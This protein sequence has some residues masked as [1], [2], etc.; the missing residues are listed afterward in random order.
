[1]KNL[2]FTITIFLLLTGCGGGGGTDTTDDRQ[3]SESTR[4]TLPTPPEYNTTWCEP[5]TNTSWQWQLS[6]T[7]NSSYDVTV[8]D[9]DLFETTKETIQSLQDSGKKV[10]CYFSGGSFEDWRPDKANFPIE[11][12]GNNLDGWDGEKWLDIRNDKVKDI[13]KTRLDL[14][15]TKGCNGVEPD[16]IDGYDNSSGFDFTADDQLEYNT[17]IANEAH[18][19]GLSVGLKNDLAQVSLLEPY[20]DFS[21]SEEC[22]QNNECEQL[23]PFIQSNKPVFNAE[24]KDSYVS[25]INGARDDM[26]QKSNE[27]KFQTLV[28]PLNLDDTFRYS[29]QE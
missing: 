14:A 29:C 26:C 23:I 1:M 13:M 20:F 3:S 5:T 11:A 17:F 10:I 24:Y 25:N 2:I 19:R 27:L 15:K 21:V 4:N 28:L 12:L 7:I 8:Y 18:K 16:N 6:K 9:I 22:F